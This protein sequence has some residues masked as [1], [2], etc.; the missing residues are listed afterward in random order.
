MVFL[1]RSIF[2]MLLLFVCSDVAAAY[3]QSDEVFSSCAH[4]PCLAIIDAGSTGTRLHLFSY[5]FDFSNQTQSIQEMYT[6]AEKPGLANVDLT[7][8]EAYLSTLVP[9]TE[10]Q[11]AF[12]IPIYVYATAGMRLRNEDDQKKYYQT[13]QSWFGHH[14]E[15]NLLEA[16]TITGHEEGLFG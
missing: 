13:I 1:Y 10:V 4:K 14:P 6:H 2:N 9:T 16:R 5:Q 8:I 15:W 3:A 7:S 11:S 12:P